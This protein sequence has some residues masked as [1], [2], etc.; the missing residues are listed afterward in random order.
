MG[1]D[2]AI[3]VEIAFWAAFT[4]DFLT[5]LAATLGTGAAEGSLGVRAL[6]V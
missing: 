2:G 5:G 3:D 6:V 4:G 1:A